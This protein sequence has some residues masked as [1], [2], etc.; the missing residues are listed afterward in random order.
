MGP[1]IKIE[2]EVEQWK[3]MVS[4]KK[5]LKLTEQPEIYNYWAL[6]T[7]SVEHVDKACTCQIQEQ[8]HTKK[9]R[10]K[11]DESEQRGNNITNK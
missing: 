11:L 2:K 3:H 10:F 5:Q 6:L 1:A 9:V 7:T 8:D 4:Q